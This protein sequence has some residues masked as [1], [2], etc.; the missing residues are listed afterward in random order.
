MAA[1]KFIVLGLGS[2][3]SALARRLTKNGRQVM[4]V[5]SDRERVDQLKDELYETVIADVT[6]RGSLEELGLK[7]AAAVFISLGEDISQ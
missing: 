2:F 7:D 3:G 6:D 4:G 5:D 1:K